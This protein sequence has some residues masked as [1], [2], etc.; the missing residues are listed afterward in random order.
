MSIESEIFK[1]SV[2]DFAKLVSYG[3]CR[4]QDGYVYKETFGSGKFEARLWVQPDGK[5]HGDVY[6]LDSDDVFLPLRIEEMNAGFV[7]TVREGY[8]NILCQIRDFCCVQQYFLTKQANR[9]AHKLK[10][11]YGDDPCFLWEKF[12]GYGVFKNPESDK[13]Y[14]LIANLDFKKI[15][16]QQ[17]GEV[18]IINLKSDEQKIPLL[19]KKNGFYPAYHMNKKTW[20]TVILNETV[21]DDELLALI[22]ES[23]QYSLKKKR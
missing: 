14:A 5:V 3:F 19:L 16:P 12:S 9:I 23:H 11:I 1:R 4:T 10:E 17:S 8:V 2:F 22:N 6:D 13:W 15:N 21:T 7:G 20:I 18:D